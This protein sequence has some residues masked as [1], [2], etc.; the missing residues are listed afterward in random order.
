MRVKI[1]I[2]ATM[3][4]GLCSEGESLRRTKGM[5]QPRGGWFVDQFHG[6]LP[7]QAESE[8]SSGE[9]SCRGRGI[10]GTEPELGCLRLLSRLTEV[11]SRHDYSKICESQR[12]EGFGETK[13][14][15]LREWASDPLSDPP[16]HL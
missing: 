11:P 12:I 5:C 4:V 6:V 1:G 8:S 15:Q 13:L 10:V 9:W 14:F 16:A 7:S 3:W 2:M